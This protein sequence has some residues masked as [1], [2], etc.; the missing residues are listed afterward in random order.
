MDSY[1]LLSLISNLNFN[2][3][4]IQVAKDNRSLVQQTIRII[5]LLCQG[6]C[7]Y[8]SDGTHYTH[9]V[10]ILNLKISKRE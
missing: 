4:K 1:D 8:I 9:A 10:I 5:K 6:T 2:H 7:T 3:C